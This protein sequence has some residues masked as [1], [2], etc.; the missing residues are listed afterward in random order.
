MVSVV[1]TTI[2]MSM[3]LLRRLLR[4]IA[5]IV[6]LIAAIGCKKKEAGALVDA[7]LDQQTAERCALIGTRLEQGRVDDADLEFIGSYGH[8]RAGEQWRD[9]LRRVATRTLSPTDLAW[10]RAEVTRGT[11]LC[12]DELWT[13]LVRVIATCPVAWKG[14]F[15]VVSPDM[16]EAVRAKGLSDEVRGT[17]AASAEASAKTTTTNSTLGDLTTPKRACDLAS[18][19]QAKVGPACTTVGKRHEL[20]QR[21]AE[22]QA[23]AK[24]ERC[25]ATE[26]ARNKCFADICLNL[27]V[28]EPRNALCEEQCEKRFP[29]PGCRASGGGV[30]DPAQ[31]AITSQDQCRARLSATVTSCKLACRDR[32]SSLDPGPKREEAVRACEGKCYDD[33]SLPKCN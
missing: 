8:A 14:D 29:A 11:I 9:V 7:A 33:P 3:K 31:K 28:N 4:T 15:T 6:V 1:H 20:A 25:K 18:D 30:A 2:G 16:L 23:K 32:L 10:Q 19:L 17:V 27:D 13:A 24:E 26:T 5:A 22:A 21:Q 12:G